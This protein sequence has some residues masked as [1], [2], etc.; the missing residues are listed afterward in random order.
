[1]HGEVMNAPAPATQPT[2]AKRGW[3]NV[4]R[5]RAFT[6]HLLTSATIVGIVCALIFFVW[7]PHPYFGATGAG[8]VLRVLVAVDL[9]LGPLLTLVVFK[10]GKRGLEFDLAVIAL[11]QLAALVYGLTVMYRERPYY[12]VFAVD[13]FHVLALPDVEPSEL[14]D[15]GLTAPERIGTKPFAGPLLLSATPPSDPAVRSR[16]IEETIFE[17]KRDI[18]GRPTYWSTYESQAAQAA[19][20][21]RPLAMLRSSRPEAAGAVDALVAKLDRPESSLGFLP[22]IA[23]NHDVAMIVDTA[24]GLPLD[25]VDV[26]P[27]I[28][29]DA[30]A[31]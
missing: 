7:Y 27:W 10:P 20:R 2:V 28:D 12:T 26:D 8:T 5:A 23:K 16:L 21:A 17:G 4:S 18:E 31:E 3:R 14:A 13:R 30:P 15:P 29:A 11:V 9:V 6:T 25:V 22:M 19:T 1:M 24:T